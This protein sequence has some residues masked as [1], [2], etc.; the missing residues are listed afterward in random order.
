MKLQEALYWTMSITKSSF[1]GTVKI[2]SPWYRRWLKSGSC[3]SGLL[4]CITNMRK[5]DSVCITFQRPQKIIYFLPKR[6][7]NKIILKFAYP[8]K[9]MVKI[10]RTVKHRN[11]NED[12]SLSWTYIFFPYWALFLYWIWYRMEKWHTESL[13]AITANHIY[14]SRK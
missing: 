13:N 6:N 1:E 8:R 4:L 14:S 10:F 3:I 5:K 9:F 12:S 11:F 7:S 2:Q